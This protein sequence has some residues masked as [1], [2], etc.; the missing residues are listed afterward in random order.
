M[1]SFVKFLKALWVEL[2]SV[3][4]LF[5]YLGIAY[6]IHSLFGL[7]YLQ[8][9]GVVFVYFT[10]NLLRIVVEVIRNRGR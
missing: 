4:E 3:I 6:G 7:T 9:I 8:S 5:I 1:N 2:D 10:L